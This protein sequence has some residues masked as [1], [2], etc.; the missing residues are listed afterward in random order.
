MNNK[1]SFREI[2]IGQLKLDRQNP[3]LPE[4]IKGKDTRAVLNWMLSDATLID[5]MAS[6]AE[7]GFFP[8]EPIIAMNDGNGHVVSL[9]KAE[10][11]LAPCDLITLMPPSGPKSLPD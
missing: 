7:N 5:L 2:D 3:R 11:K 10:A 6:I 1:D 8:G 9:E 4:Q